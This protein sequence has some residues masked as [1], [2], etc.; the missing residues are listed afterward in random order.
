MKYLKLFD[1]I[2]IIHIPGKAFFIVYP[3]GNFAYADEKSNPVLAD[4]FKGAPPITAEE[5]NRNFPNPLSWSLK[6]ACAFTS[7]LADKE[8][9][10]EVVIKRP[11]SSN[12][13]RTPNS[14][15]I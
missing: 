6:D 13:I 5:F 8:N 11:H 3:K 4:F 9:K 7:M 15:Y 1:K 12:H 14:F 2:F 10:S